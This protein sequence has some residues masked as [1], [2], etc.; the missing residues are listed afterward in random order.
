[1]HCKTTVL[2]CGQFVFPPILKLGFQPLSLPVGLL[3]YP[4]L[5]FDSLNAMNFW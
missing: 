5:T 4:D 3:A 1:M 2:R